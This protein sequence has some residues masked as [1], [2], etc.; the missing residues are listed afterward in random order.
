VRNRHSPRELT[1]EPPGTSALRRMIYAHPTPEATTRRPP[2][3]SD[4]P[5][6]HRSGPLLRGRI[7]RISPIEPDL[8][9]RSAR[10]DHVC[11]MWLPRCRRGSNGP[12]SIFTLLPHKLAGATR[13]WRGLSPT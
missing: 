8:S 4:Q 7:P 12:V 6:K 10:G 11:G 3:W 13:S 1:E 2:P 9:L 5:K